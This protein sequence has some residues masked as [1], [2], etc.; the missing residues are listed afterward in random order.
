[1]PARW[2]RDLFVTYFGKIPNVVVATVLFSVRR[3]MQPE[4]S[5][6]HP[7]VAEEALNQLLTYYPAQATKPLSMQRA[8]AKKI[9]RGKAAD[10]YRH[11]EPLADVSNADLCDSPTQPLGEDERLLVR[12]AALAAC[13]VL[14]ERHK[15]KPPK[16]AM[17]RFLRAEIEAGRPIPSRRELAKIGGVGKE[18]GCNLLLEFLAEFK[19][20]LRARGV[21]GTWMS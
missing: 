9:T 10:F 11:R 19:A 12:E 17:I 8:L 18:Q 21:D 14:A 2:V 13:D 5:G 1:V 15:G 7:H 6:H 4:D 16:F 20:Q 3:Y